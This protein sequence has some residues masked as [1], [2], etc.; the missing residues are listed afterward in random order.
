[1]DGLSAHQLFGRDFFVTDKVRK[2]TF[3][4]LYMLLDS[5]Q[6]LAQ[7]G[8]GLRRAGVAQREMQQS[9]AGYRSQTHCSIALLPSS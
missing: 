5:R 4:F 2:R 1:M 3:K 6:D 9:Q 7:L 8:H